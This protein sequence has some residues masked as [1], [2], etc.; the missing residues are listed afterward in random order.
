MVYPIIYKVFLHP[1]WL[2]GISSIN[3]ITGV[4]DHPNILAQPSG[5]SGN[6]AD[7]VSMDSATSPDAW[8]RLTTVSTRGGGGPINVKGCCYHI[9]FSQIVGITKRMLENKKN[10]DTKNSPC[11]KGEHPFQTKHPVFGSGFVSIFWEV[12]F[13]TCS[14][15]LPRLKP[16]PGHRGNASHCAWESLGWTKKMVKGDR[17]QG[18]VKVLALVPPMPSKKA[19][20]R[21]PYMEV[22]SNIYNKQK[23]PPETNMNIYAVY[24]LLVA[25]TLV[26]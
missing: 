8:R 5:D 14:G 6:L 7:I 10:K 9:F 1:G 23:H 12:N 22:I 17:I 18:N 24:F 3:S 4:I 25:N 21:F 19:F 15:R 13:K 2:F 11:L 26:R 16:V 20:L